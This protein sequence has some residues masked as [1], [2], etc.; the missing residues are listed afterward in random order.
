MTGT[1]VHLSTICLT[2]QYLGFSRKRLQYVAL[3]C[4]DNLRGRFMAEISIFDPDML[5]WVDES[6]F[7]RKNT[8][9]A[10]GYGIRG[11]PAKDQR[12]RHSGVKINSIAVMSVFGVEDVYLLESSVDG[13]T[14][15]DFCRKC[16]LPILMP[17]N[18]VNTHSVVVMDNCSIHHVDTI[19]QMIHSSGALLRF[20]PP[21]SPDLNPIEYTFFKVK[22]FVKAN[23]SVFPSYYSFNGF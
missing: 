16:L 20:L 2:V 14:F 3:Q 23:D 21:Y 13:E 10:Y 6:G 19:T 9:R 22:S 12:L 5:V 4:D 11:L 1:Y 17:L 8:I 15:E 18:G 7:N